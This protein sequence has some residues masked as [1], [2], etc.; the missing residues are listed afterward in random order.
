MLKIW[1]NIDYVE[2]PFKI[3]KL[4]GLYFP[5][6]ENVIKRRCQIIYSY[7]LFFVFWSSGLFMTYISYAKMYREDLSKFLFVLSFDVIGVL[8]WLNAFIFIFNRNKV[9]EIIKLLSTKYYQPTTEIEK[10][11]YVNTY[12][13]LR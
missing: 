10:K 9:N 11:I 8:V 6:E 13:G 7:T 4:A 5:T 3:F 12:R 2:F 1:R